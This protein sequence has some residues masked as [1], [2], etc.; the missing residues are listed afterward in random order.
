LLVSLTSTISL[1]QRRRLK[2]AVRELHMICHYSLLTIG[3]TK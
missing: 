2:I 3:N 1:S